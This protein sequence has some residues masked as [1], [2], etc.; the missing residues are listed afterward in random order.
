MLVCSTLSWAAQGVAD[1]EKL[2]EL[3]AELIEL[4]FDFE[5]AI[6]NVNNLVEAQNVSRA[7]WVRESIDEQSDRAWGLA[8]LSDQY[9][10]DGDIMEGQVFGFLG[11]WARSILSGL[12]ALD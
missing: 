5:D 6:G 4:T 8:A 2:G 7:E 12:R 1:E 9:T 11:A 10:D 3:M